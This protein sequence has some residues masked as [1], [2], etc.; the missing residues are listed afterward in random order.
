MSNRISTLLTSWHMVRKFLHQIQYFAFFEADIYRNTRNTLTV[1]SIPESISPLPL[2]RLLDVGLLIRTGPQ[3]I[4]RSVTEFTRLLVMPHI[5]KHHTCRYHRGSIA[6]VGNGMC[7]D[8]NYSLCF[9][10]LSRGVWI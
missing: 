5:F 6:G 4:L 9:P 2:E 10:M 1:R 7:P 3:L 8:R